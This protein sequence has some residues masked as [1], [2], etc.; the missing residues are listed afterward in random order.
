MHFWIVA[1]DH[2]LQLT[3][4]A[5]DSEKRRA[6]KEQLEAILK[7]GLAERHID[8]IA[9]ESKLEKATIASELANTAN[10]RI[11]RTNIMMTDAEREAAGILEAL[12]NRPGHLDWDTMQYWIERRIPEDDV[13][14]EYFVRRTLDEAL[15]AKN[16]LML[17]GDSHVDAVSEKL[18]RV[19]HGVETNHELFPVKRWELEIATNTMVQR[20]EMIAEVLLIAGLPGSGKTTHIE[21]MQDQGWTIFDDFK[22]NAYNDSS[23]FR[24]SRHY[25]ALIKALQNGQKC[26]VAD[27]DFCRVASRNQAESMI[28]AQFPAISLNWWF[29]AN[30]VDACRSNIIRRASRSIEDNLRALASYQALYRIPADARVLPVWAPNE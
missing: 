21:T 3:R 2:E 7:A 30:N 14:E 25:E 1:I 12:K 6:Q 13:R 5:N 17:L 22:A 15:C 10:P 24:H 23:M 19:G 28:R 8:F 4:A 27:I 20:V 18:Q 26:I 11:P 29:F 9:E 16:V